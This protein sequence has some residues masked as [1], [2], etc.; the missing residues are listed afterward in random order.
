MPRLLK[1]IFIDHLSKLLRTEMST[2]IETDEIKVDKAHKIESGPNLRP[3]SEVRFNYLKSLSRPLYSNCPADSTCESCQ[4]PASY[5]DYT[6]FQTN[7]GRVKLLKQKSKTT[8]YLMSP[9]ANFESD[10]DSSTVSIEQTSKQ[11]NA[12]RPTNQRN[13]TKCD[14]MLNKAT[15]RELKSILASQFDPL[16]KCLMDRCECKKIK[17]SEQKKLAAIQNEWSDVA[18]VVDH[19]LCYFF[20]IVTVLTPFLVFIN[21]PHFFSEW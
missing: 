16:I 20:P 14:Y 17:Q 12:T 13:D 11:L 10:F 2:A 21:S 19:L 3:V 9:L 4:N 18:K 5:Y 7:Q 6:S 1:L 8:S 15:K